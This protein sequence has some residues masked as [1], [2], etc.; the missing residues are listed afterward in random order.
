MTWN[1]QLPD[2]PHFRYNV[3]SLLPS[4]RAFMQSSGTALTLSRTID[5]ED[6][7]QLV[8]DLLCEEALK[9]SE[10]E[11][12]L[13][14]PESVRSS[15][16]THFG[17]PSS[18]V[19]VPVKERSIADMMVDA[20]HTWSEPLTHETLW[21]WHTL[22]MGS[23]SRLKDRG[24]YR[25]HDEPMQIVS[26]RLDKQTVFFEAPPSKEVM[27]EMTAFI[28]WFNEP[29]EHE[30]LLG[31]A[32]VAHIYFE[33]IHPFED[34]NGRI[35][36][37]LVEKL[38]ARGLGHPSLLPI[39]PIIERRKKEYYQNLGE[40]NRTLEAGSW[41][42]FFAEVLVQAQERAVKLLNF[43]LVKTKMMS[44]LSGQL[45]P[46]MEKALLRLFAAGPERYSG[47][48][49]AENYISIT[50][51]SRATATRDLAELVHV[52]ALVKT[53]EL[54][55]TRYWLNLAKW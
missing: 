16:L 52:G 23:E 29:T 25:S 10:I 45:N 22:L 47:G 1:W 54:R 14:Q 40:C 39:S 36:R 21:R 30:P 49:S 51:A 8:I 15:L 27:K 41:V 37:A 28:Q 9:S 4:E 35:G 55:Y 31:R 33:S 17:L 24:A 50:K 19:R 11:G 44:K 42:T 34:G 12:E 13:L 26:N 53:G 43:L 2:W 7:A 18:N 3:S 48:L 20:Y 32:A 46:R 5:D 6:R 38:L